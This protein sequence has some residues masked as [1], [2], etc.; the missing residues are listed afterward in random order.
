MPNC[1]YA[2]F[3]HYRGRSSRTVPVVNSGCGIPSNALAYSVNATV[4]PQGPLGF[5]TMWPS[6][7]AQPFVSTLNAT[8]G[9]IV[10]NAAIVPAGDGGAISAYATNATH[11]VLDINGYFAA[12]GGANAQRFFPCRPAGT[13]YAQS[14]WE[15]WRSDIAGG[16]TRTWPVPSSACGLPGSA[17]LIRS[18]RPWCR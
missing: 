3:V 4:V 17:L 11:L 7:R 12:P 16:Q 9:E 8:T 2:E 5:L 10:A 15:S 18:M 14:E 1:R 13:G 6:G